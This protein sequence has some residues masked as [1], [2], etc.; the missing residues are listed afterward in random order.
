MR[1]R[2]PTWW[3]HGR[4]SRLGLSRPTASGAVTLRGA[5][6][7]RPRKRGVISTGV[8]FKHD[9]SIRVPHDLR[10]RVDVRRLAGRDALG[11][12]LRRTR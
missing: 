10:Y 12:R 5:V 11:R 1:I 2:D 7:E 4:P 9:L 3:T 8:Y 6:A